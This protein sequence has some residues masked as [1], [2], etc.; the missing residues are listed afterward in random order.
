MRAVVLTVVLLTL[1]GVPGASAQVA[2]GQTASTGTASTAASTAASTGASSG[3]GPRRFWVQD[4][5]RYTSP[6]FAG[7]HRKMVGFGCTRAPYYDPDPR[8]TDDHGFHHGLDLAMPCGT[9]L[10]AGFPGWVVRPASP[11]A[12]GSAYGPNAFRIRN[13]DKGVDVVIGHVKKVY[14]AP[15]DRVRTGRLIARA[16]K[17]GAPDGCHLHFEVRPIGGGYTSA[18]RPHPYLMLQ[19]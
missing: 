13:H 2:A 11:G 3:D 6:W 17:L 18:V 5:H 9:E 12:L 10:F 19:R 1:L 7:A 4:T 8:C 16:N 15:G 14:V